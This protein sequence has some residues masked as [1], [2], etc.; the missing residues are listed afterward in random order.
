M[1]TVQAIPDKVAE[2][3]LAALQNFVQT[4][5][6]ALDAA[7]DQQQAALWRA[8]VSSL[9]ETQLAAVQSASAH[10]A[11]GDHE[12]LT[13][14]AQRSRYLARDTDGY[15]LHF[16]GEDFAQQLEERR[17]L[18]VFAAWQVCEAAGAV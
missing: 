6:E 5:R 17:R 3:Y 9:L 15:S 11:I 1:S 4:S 12:P 18:V 13:A 16:A 2:R 7:H 14:L 10:H 8:Q